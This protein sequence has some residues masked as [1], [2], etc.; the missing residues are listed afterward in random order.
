MYLHATDKN[1]VKPLKIF[2]QSENNVINEN[3]HIFTK[4]NYAS[5]TI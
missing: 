4:S 5:N 2:E 3:W 1:S